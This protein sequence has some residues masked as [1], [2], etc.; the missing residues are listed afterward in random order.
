MPKQSFD[1]F[2]QQQIVALKNNLN[3]KE[4][5]LMSKKNTWQ[6]TGHYAE[7]QPGTEFVGV[8]RTRHIIEEFG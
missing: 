1:T 5:F 4:I 3:Y 8:I 2:L 7:T 6:A